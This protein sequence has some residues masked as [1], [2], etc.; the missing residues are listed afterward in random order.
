MAGNEGGG[1]NVS[2]LQS[3]LHQQQSGSRNGE[4]EQETALSIFVFL[5]WFYKNVPCFLDST[6]G[7][8]A[9][10]VT[11]LGAQLPTTVIFG[12]E[13]R[14]NIFG[15]PKL[16]P[17]SQ[18]EGASDE[19]GGSE[20]ATAANG[21]NDG[22]SIKATHPDDP[23]AHDEYPHAN[24]EVANAAGHGLDNVDHNQHQLQQEPEYHHDHSPSPTPT[25]SQQS[26][27]D[28]AFH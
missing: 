20:D 22:D 14:K 10:S 9:A 23:Y 6:T 26:Q 11:C 4:E 24:Q 16:L 8:V 27:Y 15:L 12:S 5:A 13:M 2:A 19:G 28:H 18:P 7:N 17:D 25:T 21:E 1:I 3:Y